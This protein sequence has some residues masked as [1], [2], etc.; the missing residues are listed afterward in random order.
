[1]EIRRKDIEKFL[2]FAIAEDIGDGDHTSLAT[3]GR[4][5]TGKAQLLVKAK[6]YYCRS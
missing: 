6:W 4:N 5:H 2:D 1:M 3:I